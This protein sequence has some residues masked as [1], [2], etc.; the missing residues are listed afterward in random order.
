MKADN[1]N[2]FEAKICGYKMF[3]FCKIDGDNTVGFVNN[4][5]QLFLTQILGKQSIKGVDYFDL[6]QLKEVLK[7]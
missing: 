3:S 5:I 4:Y 1:D 2:T 7:Y 6:R